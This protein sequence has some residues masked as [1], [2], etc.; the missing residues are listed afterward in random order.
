MSGV[1]RASTRTVTV[2]IL[3]Y[4]ALC[5]LLGLIMTKQLGD[6]MPSSLATRIGHDSEGFF[7]A[8]VLAAWIQFGRWRLRGA[9]LWWTSSAVSFLLLAGGV[10]L[11]TSGNIPTSVT[12]LDEACYALAVLIPFVGVRRPCGAWPLL[13][14]AILA[15]AVGVGVALFPGSLIVV[16]AETIATLILAPWVFDFFDR[17]ILNSQAITTVRLRLL[18]Y[19]LLIAIPVI[20]VSLGASRRADGG[21]I[22]GVL[23][24][25]GRSQESFVA[26]LFVSAFLAVGLG[27]TGRNSLHSKESNQPEDSP[28]RPNAQNASSRK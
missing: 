28:L 14:S 2:S 23:N 8:L 20:V 22:N 26:I 16:L 5:L 9:R 19:I 4:G 7:M 24:Y 17:G 3:Y 6:L 25:I 11:T 21:F 18:G 12:T 13:M 10:V 15:V 27:A 1:G